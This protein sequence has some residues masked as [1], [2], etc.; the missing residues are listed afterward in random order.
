MS[1]RNI[2]V[3]DMSLINAVGRDPQGVFAHTKVDAW[4]VVPQG[5][6]SL[7]DFLL[8]YSAPG[9]A[10]GVI[11]LLGEAIRQTMEI[12][13]SY[14]QYFKTDHENTIG[15]LHGAILLYTGEKW[16][17]VAVHGFDPIMKY[18]DMQECMSPFYL[19]LNDQ[20]MIT[21]A[22]DRPF[23]LRNLGMTLHVDIPAYEQLSPHR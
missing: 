8:K 3:Y 23:H 19:Q 12:K 22:S 1:E 16:C 17:R 5:M 6:Q 2:H 20:G 13:K 10:A 4:E 15:R 14:N 7:K 9:Q 11:Q 18:R 21:A